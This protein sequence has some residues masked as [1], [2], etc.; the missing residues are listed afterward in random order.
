VG[1]KKTDRGIS[2][3]TISG[4][5]AVGLIADDAFGRRPKCSSG[6]CLTANPFAVDQW[7]HLH[8]LGD[9]PIQETIKVEAED[10]RR[11]RWNTASPTAKKEYKSTIS[12]M[13]RTASALTE[14]VASAPFMAEADLR[15]KK[16][17]KEATLRTDTAGACDLSLVRCGV[18]AHAALGKESPLI[19][20]MKDA[21]SGES[22]PSLW[23]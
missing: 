18:L 13:K 14:P 21:C 5:W 7:E 1:K 20:R 17:F 22:P 10:D 23:S 15:P 19:Q 6:F 16:A 2:K 12:T 9:V 4:L 8:H 3:I 11:P